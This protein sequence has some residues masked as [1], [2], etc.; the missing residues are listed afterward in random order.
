M[1]SGLATFFRRGFNASSHGFNPAA[2]AILHYPLRALLPVTPWGCVAFI[3]VNTATVT[4]AS[5]SLIKGW[6]LL[7]PPPIITAASFCGCDP[8]QSIG[9]RVLPAPWFATRRTGATFDR[10]AYLPTCMRDASPARGR[11][12]KISP[13]ALSDW[14]LRM[15]LGDSLYGPTRLAILDCSCGAAHR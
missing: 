9:M 13:D 3:R 10:Q 6:L 14:G 7:S 1:P 4:S 2:H 11:H 8:L 12:S 15:P 5:H